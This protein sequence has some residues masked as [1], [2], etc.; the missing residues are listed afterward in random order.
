[1]VAATG[2]TTSSALTTTIDRNMKIIA[3]T[4]A[5]DGQ[6]I[7]TDENLPTIAPATIIDTLN[8]RWLNEGLDEN[9]GSMDKNLTRLNLCRPN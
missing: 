4:F 7:S 6:C 5:N 8:Y 3:S 1:M 9:M 2:T